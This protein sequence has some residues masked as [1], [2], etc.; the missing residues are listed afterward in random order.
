M[1]TIAQQIE[2]ITTPDNFIINNLKWKFLTRSVLRSKNILITGPAGSGKTHVATLAA[3]AAGKNVHKINLGSTQEPR[4][5]LIGN[6]HFKD[7]E[8][9]FEPSAFVKALQTPNTVIILD[10]FSRMHPDAENI[11]MTVL[12]EDQRYLRI[13]D[14]IDTPIVKVHESV[15]FIATANIGSEY[16]ATR[17]LDRATLDRFEILEM[18]ELTESQETELLSKLYPNLPEMTISN[19][20]NLA[21]HTRIN[22]A[23]DDGKLSTAISTRTT[24]RLCELVSDGFSFKESLQIG[25]IPL[26]DKTGGVESERT[27]IL[28]LL[29]KYGIGDDVDDTTAESPFNF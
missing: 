6:T 22:C 28:Q 26:F 20:A 15:S 1:K 9:I 24:K 11:L 23:T 17:V 7:N 12:D 19:I 5:A 29:Q 14:A 21:H 13:D 8:T 2:E 18:D 4:S 3:E 25:A 27:Y 16:T 10:E